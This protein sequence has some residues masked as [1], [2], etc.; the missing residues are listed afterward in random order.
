MEFATYSSLSDFVSYAQSTTMPLLLLQMQLLLPANQTRVE[1]IP[2]STI[3]HSLSHLATYISIAQLLRSIPYFAGSKRT[4]VIPRDVASANKVVD[5]QVFRALPALSGPIIPGSP[6]A[7]AIENAIPPLQA[8]CEELCTLAEGE[9]SK[10]RATLGLE[11]AQDDE[12]AELAQGRNLSSLPSAVSPVFLSAVPAIN[13]FAQLKQANYNPFEPAFN[14]PQTR[15]WKL[16]AQMW[17]ANF[18]RQV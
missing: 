16:P 8:A 17:W 9:R 14:Q 15:N 3:D 12:H 4:M 5:E 18:R 1:D 13:T 11:A 2:L 10:A 6:S 7:N